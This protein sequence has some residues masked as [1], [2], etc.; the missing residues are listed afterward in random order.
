MWV[1]GCIHTDMRSLWAYYAYIHIITYLHIMRVFD[2]CSFSL[3]TRVLYVLLSILMRT[4]LDAYE[5]R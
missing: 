4:Y 1:Y 2:F 5:Y 3:K